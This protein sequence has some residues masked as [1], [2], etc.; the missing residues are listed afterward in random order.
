MIELLLEFYILRYGQV[1]ENRAMNWEV[2]M[3]LCL[4]TEDRI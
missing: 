2:E 1:W 3:F 4:G